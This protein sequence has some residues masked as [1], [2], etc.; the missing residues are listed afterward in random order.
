MFRVEGAFCFSYKFKQI[1]LS[2]LEHLAGTKNLGNTA[3]K[4][5]PW[6]WVCSRDC[7]DVLT[8]RASAA[9]ELPAPELSKPL[10]KISNTYANKAQ[11]HLNNL[12]F[13]MLRKR[14]V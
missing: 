13:Q 8:M 2:K 5:P 7:C 11:R 14:C 4:L 10:R 3:L 1:C 6:L 12:L 9:V